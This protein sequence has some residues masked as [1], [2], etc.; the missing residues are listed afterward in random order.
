MADN[1][2]QIYLGQSG[3]RNAMFQLTAYLKNIWSFTTKIDACEQRWME[4]ELQSSP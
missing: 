3:E 1:L 4:P 2:G